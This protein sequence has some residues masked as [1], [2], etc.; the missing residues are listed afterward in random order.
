MQEMGVREAEVANQV[1]W[2][3]PRFIL[4]GVHC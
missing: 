1:L 2:F 3:I 4:S